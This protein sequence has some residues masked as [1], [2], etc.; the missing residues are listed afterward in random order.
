M[1]GIAALPDYLVQ[2]STNVVR[3]LNDIEGPAFPAYLVYTQEAR[4]SRRIS[5]F[6]E[7]IIEQF[8]EARFWYHFIYPVMLR[9]YCMAGLRI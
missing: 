8:K 1:C 3:I 9:V 5:V 2:G 7:Y 4:N 6:K